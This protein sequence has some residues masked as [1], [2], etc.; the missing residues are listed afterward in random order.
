MAKTELTQPR[1]VRSGTPGPGRE[2]EGSVRARA[3]AF[4]GLFSA[5]RG[6]TVQPRARRGGGLTA[7]GGDSQ[8]RTDAC[9]PVPNKR[10][11]A[12]PRPELQYD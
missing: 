3:G 11:T 12:I 7:I 9:E 8:G 10:D 4:R 1:R 2:S 6:E 5:D